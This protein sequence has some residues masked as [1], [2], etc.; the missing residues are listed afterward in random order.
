MKIKQRNVLI[1]DPDPIFA[2]RLSVTL[3]CR[4]CDVETA[5]GVTQAVQRMKDVCFDCVIADEDLPEMKG[6]DAVSVL[7][8][9]SPKTPIIVTAARNTLERESAIRRQDVFYYYVKSVE[10][11]ELEM[12]VWDALRRAGSRT[13]PPEGPPS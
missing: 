4:G 5:E 1:V 10:M 7:K 13:F 12:A 11:V 6:H 9:I 2:S 8:A 3:S